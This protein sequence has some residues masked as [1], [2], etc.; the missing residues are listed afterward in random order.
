MH[1]NNVECVVSHPVLGIKPD[2]KLVATIGKVNE[3]KCLEE[4]EKFLG[5]VNFYG[6]RIRNFAQK[7]EPLNKLR[8]NGV[9]FV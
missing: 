2:P 7:C 9:P 1:S 8:K 4:V 5:L 3:P 6:N